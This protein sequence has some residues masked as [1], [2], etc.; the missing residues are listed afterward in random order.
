MKN[1]DISRFSTVGARCLFTMHCERSLRSQCIVNVVYV[2]TRGCPRCVR[3]CAHMWTGRVRAC[4]HTWVSRV[5][6]HTHS[7]VRT[8][9]VQGDSRVKRE[10]EFPC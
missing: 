3:V 1:H 5:C 8:N 2:H 6:A 4:A 9:N 10:G 7:P